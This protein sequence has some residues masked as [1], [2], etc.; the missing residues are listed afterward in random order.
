MV[1][2]VQSFL[3]QQIA[4]IF[5]KG[6]IILLI[7]TSSYL[8]LVRYPLKLQK[9]A[10]L[11][12]HCKHSLSGNQ[13]VRCFNLKNLEHDMRYKVDLLLPLKLEK[14]FSYGL[15]PKRLFANQF[16]GLFTFDLFDLINL[17]PGGHCYIVVLV[18]KAFFKYFARNH[19][20]LK[21]WLAAYLL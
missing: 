7:F 11:G 10:I 21:I 18:S 15:W 14:I 3:K 8:H 19:G 9:Y 5:E 12:W 4:I 1:W 2:H 20:F 16:A 6:W 17:I 13:I